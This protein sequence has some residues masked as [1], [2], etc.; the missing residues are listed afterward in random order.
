[1]GPKLF[2]QF[3]QII[4][5]DNTATLLKYIQFQN[6]IYHFPER[7]EEEEEEEFICQVIKDLAIRLC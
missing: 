2:P 3:F 5:K 4:S 6:F 7:E 1:M